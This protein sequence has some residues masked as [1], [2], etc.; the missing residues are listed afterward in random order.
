MPTRLNDFG[1]GSYARCMTYP[2]VGP[3]VLGAWTHGAMP[4]RLNDFAHG[5]YAWC[6][7]ALSLGRAFWVRGRTGR[8]PRG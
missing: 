8:C 1:D 6:M 2:V 4:T 7:T 3:R 5:S